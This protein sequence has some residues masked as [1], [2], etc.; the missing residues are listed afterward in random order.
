MTAIVSLLLLVRLA[1]GA[2]EAENLS[3]QSLPVGCT[4]QGSGEL[5]GRA[6][7]VTT[8]LYTDKVTVHLSR[9]FAGGDRV[10]FAV[11]VPPGVNL[12]NPGGTRV[13]RAGALLPASVR[14]ILGTHDS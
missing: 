14:E 9:T 10:S 7:R 2:G 5:S 13:L 12:T 3:A 8:G 6:E 4:A 1:P 11:P